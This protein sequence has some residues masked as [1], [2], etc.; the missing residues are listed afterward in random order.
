MIW[1]EGPDSCC[2]CSE[3]SEGGDCGSGDLRVV[4]DSHLQLKPVAIDNFRI[5]LIYDAC[6]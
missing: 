4:V 5:Q 6:Y 1:S 2:G 3:R